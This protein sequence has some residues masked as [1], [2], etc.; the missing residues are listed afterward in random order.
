MIS[1]EFTV[2][3]T[4]YPPEPMVRYYSDGSGYPGSPAEFEITDVEVTRAW[5]DTWNLERRDRPDWFKLLD[6]II[7]SKISEVRYL[8]NEDI[9]DYDFEE[10]LGDEEW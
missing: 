8:E 10:R 4:Y 7:E 3:G 5:G 6:K 9:D 2:L 1:V